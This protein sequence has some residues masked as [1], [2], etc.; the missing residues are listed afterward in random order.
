MAWKD[1][2]WFLCIC[3]ILIKYYNVWGMYGDQDCQMCGTLC[4]NKLLQNPN[5]NVC[6]KSINKLQAIL[7]VHIIRLI[8]IWWYSWENG[9]TCIFL[10]NVD[11]WFMFTNDNNNITWID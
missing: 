9:A 1:N 2:S 5:P 10:G 7:N 4:S 11:K 6:P 8:C 3:K